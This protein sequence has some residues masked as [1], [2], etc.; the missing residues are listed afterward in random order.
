M[1]FNSKYLFAV[2]V[3]PWWEVAGFESPDDMPTVPVTSN[4]S[5]LQAEVENG[6][7]L[8]ALVVVSKTFKIFDELWEDL[9][10]GCDTFAEWLKK[11]EKRIKKKCWNLEVSF[12]CIHMFIYDATLMRGSG[13]YDRVSDLLELSSN[14]ERGT[15]AMSNRVLMCKSPCSL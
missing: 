4:Q 5:N 14:K 9:S 6:E 3:M 8:Q 11:A 7:M 15:H 12:Y 10:F 13:G 1:L 2:P